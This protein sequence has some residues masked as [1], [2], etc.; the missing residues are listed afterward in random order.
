MQELIRLDS[1]KAAELII[2]NL[3]LDNTQE[4][5]E[6][7]ENNE[8]IKTAQS[9]DTITENQLNSSDAKLH[10]RWKDNE[11][12]TATTESSEQLGLKSP[13]YKDVSSDSP[14]VRKGTYDEI[15]ELQLANT[16]NGFLARWNDFPD[17]ITEKQWTDMSREVFA[18]LP[19]DWTSYVQTGQLDALRESHKWS[20]PTV[21]TEG[22]LHG[23]SKKSASSNINEMIKSASEAVVDSIVSYGLSSDQLKRVV[24]F[25]KSSPHNHLKASYMSLVNA[26]PWFI[27]LRQDIN[28]KNRFFKKASSS[29]VEP[30][31]GFIGAISDNIGSFRAEDFIDAVNF[32]VNDPKAWKVAQDKAEEKLASIEDENNI[33]SK[34]DVFRKAF[35]EN[36]L[37]EDGLFKVCCTIKDDIGVDPSD[38]ENFLR[39]VFAYAQNSIS[40]RFGELDVVPVNVDIDDENG[41]VECTVKQASLL[42]D[43]ELLAWEKVAS[44]LNGESFEEDNY[45]EAEEDSYTKVASVSSNSDSR[46]ARIL[47]ELEKL[48]KQAQMA[49]GQMPA[50]LNPAGMGAGMQ[51]PGSGAPSDA[52]PVESLTSSVPPMG[53]P[54]SDPMSDM[55]MKDDEKDSGDEEKPVPAS[56]VCVICGGN[57]VN[58]GGGQAD[59]KDGK[60]GANYT[61]KVVPDASLLDKIMDGKVDESDMDDSKSPA[62]VEKGLG[63]E[64][65]GQGAPGSLPMPPMAATA[66]INVDRLNKI[67]KK[68]PFGSISPITGKSNTI[69]L[70]NNTWKC[71]DSGQEYIVKVAADKMDTKSVWA[72]WEWIPE[73]KKVECSS[74]KRKKANFVNN[75]G[76]M[77]ISESTFDSMSLNNKAKT[78]IKMNENDL[79]NESKLAFTDKD[80]TNLLGLF[81]A[82]FSVGNKFPME[83]C[84]EKLARRFGDDA[85]G[86]SGPCEGK[87][88]ADC[89][90]GSLANEKMYST[91]LANKIASLWIEKEA[92]NECVEDFIRDGM[93][94][95]QASVACEQLRNKYISD[96]ELLAER[97]AKT[98]QEVDTSND[99]ADDN[100]V[101]PFEGGEDSVSMEVKDV[102]IPDEAL[103]HLEQ[104]LQEVLD[105]L[106]PIT[107]NDDSG[108]SI[109]KDMKGS[110]M[111]GSDMEGSDMEGSDME[112]SDM[113]GSDMEGS[114]MEGSDMEGSDMEGSD[115]EGSDMGDKDAAMLK[116]APENMVK[117]EGENYMDKESQAL[118]ESLKRGKIVGVNKLNF[119]VSKLAEA[120]NMNKSAEGKKVTISNPQDQKEVG[121]IS[122]G[123]S[124]KSEHGKGFDVKGPKVPGNHGKKLKSEHGDSFDDTAYPEVPVDGPSLEGESGDYKP[125]KGNMMTG[126]QN[127][128]GSSAT[129]K[130]QMTR[131]AFEENLSKLAKEMGLSEHAV[132]ED[133]DIQPVKGKD[134]LEVDGFDAVENGGKPLSSEHGEGF[135]VDCPSIPAGEGTMGHE[136]EMGLTSEKE[137]Q[138]T[139][140]Q[141]GAGSSVKSKASKSK[142]VS[143]SSS[144][145]SSES[146]KEAAIKLAGKM[147]EHKL[148][149]VSELSNKIAELERYEVSQIRDIEKAMFKSSSVAPKGLVTASKGVERP[150]VIGETSNQRNG[151]ADLSSKISS[152]F[153]L[154]QQVN[155]AEQMDNI[156]I[157]NTFK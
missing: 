140:G 4:I 106:A 41:L 39:S 119:D 97:L 72:Q 99:M 153:K 104:G 70:A 151:F 131:S 110:D 64:S 139:G 118:S 66:K 94:I 100:E 17:V 147:I 53:G 42:N 98:A 8:N 150:I 18:K 13:K 43:E 111:E 155:A 62:D 38:D 122:S 130:Y 144:K 14:Q 22:Q 88:L 63:G 80:G 75:L 24:S 49:G 138:I 71:L 37:P 91:G 105:A 11:H 65:S 60:C 32:I 47:E 67:A 56:A 137:N 19:S 74:C 87:N 125:E 145:G 116:T 15:T 124:L 6:S 149:S 33:S 27:D 50:A 35:M 58:V 154:Q 121:T 5:R 3:L 57:N 115:M 123:K 20:E 133:P 48:E 157:R 129:G 103:E 141:L 73:Y 28:A 12:Y 142:A 1:A 61:I 114:D 30:I 102:E 45:E 107:K 34:E 44:R 143:A 2:S 59:C 77:G 40:E 89:V 69:K 108:V 132:Q 83:T 21:T 156:Q 81:K 86:L 26:A 117:E 84:L 29:S 10:P 54:G 113:E 31:D 135:D 96:E 52:P 120:L 46:R 68:I 16:K 51:V 112:G 85:L 146:V 136:K 93:S 7:M 79:I 101:D 78:I 36:E 82:A 95:K 9:K 126:G 55:S 134:S 148:I 92:S 152:L 25:V 128:S 127:G 23:G 109:E 76:K 90:C